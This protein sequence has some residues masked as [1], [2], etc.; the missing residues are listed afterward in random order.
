V[1]DVLTSN[2]W[3]EKQ[4]YSG[5]TA[6]TH[7]M[8]IYAKAGGSNFV[9]IATS[10]GLAATYQNYNLSNGTKGNG[11][12]SSAGYLTSIEAIGTN[13]WYR[14]TFTAANPSS[15]ARFLIVPILSD[16][17]TRNPTFLGNGTDGIYIWGAQMEAGAYATSYVPCLSTAVT[18]VADAAYKTGI[19]SLIGQTEG[20]LY[21]EGY[22]TP[23]GNYN[24]LMSVEEIGNYFFNIRL[25]TTNK[26]EAA[27]SGFSADFN[28]TAST[29]ATAGTYYKIAGAYKSGQ[30]VLYVNGVQIGTNATTFTVPSLT[31]FRFN[32]YNVFNE[33]K[34]TSQALLFKTRLTNAQLA[35]LTTL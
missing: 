28:I 13:G 8:S 14:I 4:G 31:Q 7:T 3:I 1:A 20:T 24:S 11:N 33:Q 16:V 27:T 34:S 29:P 10:S 19:S 12:V 21:W 6:G 17:A 25:N 9:Q 5:Y 23:A 30:S 22:V 2:H 26:I 35:E 15:D 32:V 18:R